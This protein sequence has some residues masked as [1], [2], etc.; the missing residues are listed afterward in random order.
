MFD[1]DFKLIHN[2]LDYYIRFHSL[3][4]I[5]VGFATSNELRTFS[6][7]NYNLE[8]ATLSSKTS[9]YPLTSLS[10]IYTVIEVLKLQDQGKLNL[11][12][13]V[14]KYLV[15]YPDEEAT[16]F[17]LLVHKAG[18][19]RD[20]AF[21][22]WLAKEFPSDDQLAASLTNLEILAEAKNNYNYSNLGY[23]ILGVILK[24]LGSDLHQNNE[25]GVVS[26][27]NNLFAKREVYNFIDFKAFTSSMG[28][29]KN[30]FDLTTD[31][32]HWLRK[33]ESILSKKAWQQMFQVAIEG[34]EGDDDVCI[35]WDKWKGEN[36]YQFSSYGFGS[37]ASVLLDYDANLAL[38]VLTNS[39]D[40]RYAGYF[41]S[42]LRR[43]VLYFSKPENKINLKSKINGLYR[44]K[45]YDVF[46]YDLNDK[47]F[48]FKPSDTTPFHPENY[49]LYEKLGENSY[50]ICN[51]EEDPYK[52]ETAEFLYDSSV[53]ISGFRHGGWGYMKV[54]L[55]F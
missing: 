29:Y 49:E 6:F 7:G 45:D 55:D 44:C 31:L 11:H 32:Q 50:R 23:A 38:A 4:S 10:K 37:A 9:I 5:S 42:T 46:I 21:D 40:M 43:F 22:F 33:E 12:D 52:Y 27:G 2:W 30:I 48:M 47:L 1:I 8:S 36:I 14:K 18:L 16:V 26:Y 15:S 39:S 34:K 25:R 13:K 35:P 28:L 54:Y 24:D 51:K 19:P 41:T 20:G 17:D 53:N 3:P